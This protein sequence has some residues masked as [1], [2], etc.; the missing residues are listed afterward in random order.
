MAHNEYTTHIPE[1][2]DLQPRLYWNRRARGLGATP[3]RPAVSRGEENL[4]G[5]VND[6]Y[7][8]KTS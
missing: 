1:H 4:L 7:A 6:P 8:S 5:Y 3:E 2:R